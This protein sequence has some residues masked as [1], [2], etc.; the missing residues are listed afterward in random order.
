MC[1]KAEDRSVKARC[2]SVITGQYC[3][4]RQFKENAILLT[5]YFSHGKDE[6]DAGIYQSTGSSGFFLLGFFFS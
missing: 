3:S 1:I 2:L 4:C 5:Q 6:L